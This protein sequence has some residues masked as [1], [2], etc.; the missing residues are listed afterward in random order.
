MASLRAGGGDAAWE[1]AV[2][3]LEARAQR[4]EAEVR[5]GGHGY[6]HRDWRC[7]CLSGERPPAYPYSLATP[8]TRP[9]R[10]APPQVSRLQAELRTATSRLVE[11]Q[12]QRDAWEGRC[13]DLL[14]KARERGWDAR[15]DLQLAG[16]EPSKHGAEVYL[17]RIAELEGECARLKVGPGHGHGGAPVQMGGCRD[18]GGGAG[19]AWGVPVADTRCTGAVQARWSCRAMSPPVTCAP[20][21]PATS[22][23]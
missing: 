21:R 14:D 12:A 13:R 8:A 10:R 2:T 16:E 1:A 11:A 20:P 3:E 18:R 4:A 9:F 6:S 22:H 17:G 19:T 5:G 23:L 15:A 7:A